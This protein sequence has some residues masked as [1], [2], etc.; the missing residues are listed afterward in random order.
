MPG[1][2]QQYELDDPYQV[3]LNYEP[4]EK[5]GDRAARRYGF[6]RFRDIKF[7]GP[8]RRGRRPD[9][10]ARARQMF[11]YEAYK[12]GRYS[13][14]YIAWVLGMRSAEGRTGNIRQEVYSM[15]KRHCEREGVEYPKHRAHKNPKVKYAKKAA[16]DK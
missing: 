3:D 6:Q 14:N 9:N 2:H 12:T 5:I 7:K 15:V 4:I 16:T 11:A 13:F 10:L 8:L 1:K